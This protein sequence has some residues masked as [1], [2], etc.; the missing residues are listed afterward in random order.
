MIELRQHRKDMD[1]SSYDYVFED[2][3]KFEEVLPFLFPK[4]E[5]E[6]NILLVEPKPACIRTYLDTSVIPSYIHLL[7]SVDKNQLEQLYLERPNLVEKERTNWDVYMDL[8]KEF[9][10]PMDDKAMREIYYRTGPKEENLRAALNELCDYTTITM[11]EVNKHFAPVNRVY[12]NQVMRAFLVGRYR[13][14]WAMLSML[15]REIGSTV[16][17][18]AMRKSI[19]RLFAEKCRY[20]QNESIKDTLVERVDGYTIILM[21]WLFE[22]ATSPEQLYPI[23]LMFERRQ[24]PC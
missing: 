19:R 7:I 17:F 2:V 15:E 16:A 23:L 20:L 18:Y 22:G 24:T 5:G 21:Y 10:V 13:Q 6:W 1:F 3:K 11:K 14:A 9:P 4:L 8:I 12:A